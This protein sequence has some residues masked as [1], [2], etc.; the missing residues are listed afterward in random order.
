VNDKYND[1]VGRDR[2]FLKFPGNKSSTCDYYKAKQCNN[3]YDSLF[4]FKASS[5]TTFH[6]NL[7]SLPINHDHLVHYLSSLSHEFSVV[8]LS[9]TWLTE[10]TTMLHDVSL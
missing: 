2:N 1:C 3:L 7:P 8:A 5:F 6:L 9:E 4:N 10:E